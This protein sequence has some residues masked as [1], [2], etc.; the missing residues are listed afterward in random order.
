MR[1]LDKQRVPNIAFGYL[2]RNKLRQ[3]ERSESRELIA[4][5][6]FVPI[7]KIKEQLFKIVLKI[8]LKIAT[9][10]AYGHKNSLRKPPIHVRMY[11]FAQKR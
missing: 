3:L 1:E 6:I 2:N 7:S 4:Q 5:M 11:I 8:V 9:F 10:A